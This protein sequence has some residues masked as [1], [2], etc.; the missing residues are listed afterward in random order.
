MLLPCFYDY[1][2]VNPFAEHDKLKHEYITN[3]LFKFQAK[4][5]QAIL[6]QFQCEILFTPKFKLRCDLKLVFFKGLTRMFWTRQVSFN[7]VPSV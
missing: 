6:A 1:G 4:L 7:L 3:I 2:N 5:E